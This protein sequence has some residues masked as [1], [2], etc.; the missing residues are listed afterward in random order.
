MYFKFTEA[1][2]KYAIDFM[3]WDVGRSEQ[4]GVVVGSLKPAQNR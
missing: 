2:K 3:Q 4:K 1:L